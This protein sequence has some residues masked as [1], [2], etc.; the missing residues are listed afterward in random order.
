MDYDY[1]IKDIWGR[2]SFA[3]AFSLVIAAILAGG[4]IDKLKQFK[5]KQVFRKKEEVRELADLHSKK[6]NTPTIGGLI[7][8]LPSLIC[9]IAF[10]SMNRM[11]YV[12]LFSYICFS[13]L[14]FFDDYR[15]IFKKNTKG[16]SAGKKLLFQLVMTLIIVAVLISQNGWYSI[17]SGVYIPFT[18]DELAMSSFFMAIL[19]FF[20]LAGS[21][22]SVNLTDGIDGLA[23]GCVIPSLA[24]FMVA[25]IISGDL[26]LSAK[27]DMPYFKGAGEISVICASVIG[28]SLVFLWHN[29]HPAEVFMGDTG[30]LALGGLIGTVAILLNQY[31]ALIMVGGIFVVEALSDI[32]QVGYFK[33]SKGK[34][35]FK[36]APL[37]HH[38]ELSGMHES[39]IVVRSWIIAIV[40]AILGIYSIFVKI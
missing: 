27:F 18:H 13:I 38:F 36:M 28:A 10:M 5:L 39:K 4:F 19:F 40:L 35:I 34:R 17:G 25:S 22:N 16:V 21:S 23:I 3:F 32:L 29:S 31:I 12:T 6:K 2:C 7:I 26:M 11:T 33:L 30:S 1:Y 8:F 14:G 20:V 9:S 37:H 24:F 15:K